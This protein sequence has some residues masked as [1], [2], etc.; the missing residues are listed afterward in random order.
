MMSA[1]RV[2]QGE[3]VKS[4]NVVFTGFFLIFFLLLLKQNKLEQNK[5]R[6][7]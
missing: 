3:L 1:V 7:V 5:S 4:V 2:H 6:Q